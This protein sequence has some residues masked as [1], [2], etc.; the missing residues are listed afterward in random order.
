M[1]AGVEIPF[2][3]TAPSPPL[4]I[5]LFEHFCFEGLNRARTANV[6]A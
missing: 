6:M 5:M 2:K 1:S 4:L 3:I